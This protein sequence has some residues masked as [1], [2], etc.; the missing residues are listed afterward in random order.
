MPSI[1]GEA[2]AAPLTAA[3]IAAGGDVY[4]SQR[5][6][7]AYSNRIDPFGFTLEGYVRSVDYATLPQDYAEIGGRL[8]L[9]W[10]V[11]IEA[12]PYAFAQYM[13]RSFASVCDPLCFSEQDTGRRIGAGVGYRLSRSLTL[14]AEVGQEERQSNVPG[15]AYVDRR[16]MLLLGYSTGPLYSARPRR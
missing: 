9:S 8:S 14:T 3:S 10:F 1:Q 13:K 15:A 6:E 4:R 16:G 12:R 11:S 2:A 7:L 5:G